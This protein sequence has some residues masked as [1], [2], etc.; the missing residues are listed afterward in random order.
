M[1]DLEEQFNFTNKLKHPTNRT[2][3]VY[4]FYV[5]EQAEYFGELLVDAQIEYEAQID[6]ED[7]RKPM[8]FGVKRIHERK[9]D[10]LN[11]TALGRGRPKFVASSQLRWIIIGISIITLLLAI[12]GAIVS[13]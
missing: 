7:E 10:K 12:I 6:E 4:R 5:R 13:N 1:I 11:Y 3:T 9:V 2:I 8:Y